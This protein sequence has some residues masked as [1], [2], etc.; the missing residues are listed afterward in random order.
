MASK[1]E[2]EAMLKECVDVVK[3]EIT[4]R[5]GGRTQDPKL[6]RGEVEFT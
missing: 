2:L 6:G 4:E 3:Q 1:T 5:N